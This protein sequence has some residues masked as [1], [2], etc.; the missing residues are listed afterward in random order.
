MTT[1]SHP[2]KVKRMVGGRTTHAVLAVVASIFLSACGGGSDPLI[3]SAEQFQEVSNQ[4]MGGGKVFAEGVVAAA[5]G[6]IYVS[7]LPMTGLGAGA[8]PR[9]AIYRYVP[10]TGI[11]TKYVEPSGMT[12]GMSFDRNNDLLR[13]NGEDGGTRNIT[14]TNLIS[15][16]Q[17]ILADNYRGNPFVSPN[18]LTV[19]GAGRIYFTD[20]RY[21]GEGPVH[22]PNAVYR[23]DADGTVTQI[24]A[25]IYRPNGIE[26][27]PDGRKLYVAAYNLDV[28]AVGV[29]A[30]PN[31]PSGDRDG[32]VG[33]VVAFDLDVS[34]NVSGRRVIYKNQDMG[35]DGM[36]IDVQG[37]LF[38][39]MHNFANGTSRM[40]AIGPDGIEKARVTPSPGVLITNLGFG[41]GA[42]GAALYASAVQFGSDGSPAWK[43]LKIKTQTHGFYR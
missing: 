24:V 4:S 25:D 16:V 30:N 31:G 12:N 20:A 10:S 32:M 5:D 26:V 17:T 27:S 22:L 19:D 11:T 41:R 2:P 29:V 33:G 36:A 23:L 15:G 42:D 21:T 3:A 14:R 1:T 13:A 39:A 37:N 43:L 28:P 6:S 40:V 9:G 18:D 7:D 35:V 38:L 8:S 34:G